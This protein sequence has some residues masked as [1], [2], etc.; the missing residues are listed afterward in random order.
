MV[1]R[2]VQNQHVHV[3]YL[4]F[5]EVP[6]TRPTALVWLQSSPSDGH[7]FKSPMRVSLG[8]NLWER[9]CSQPLFEVWL[10]SR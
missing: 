6:V 8:S 3:P 5:R 4:R 1:T 10:G 2:S 7:C 9:H